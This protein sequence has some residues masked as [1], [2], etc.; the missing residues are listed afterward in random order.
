VNGF[1]V[2]VQPYGDGRIVS[3]IEA[4]TDLC[5]ES[6]VAVIHRRVLETEDD[7]VR[8]ALIQLGWTPP[9]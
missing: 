7:A 2:T 9:A 6:V 4:V 5:G 3:Q 1:R 8:A